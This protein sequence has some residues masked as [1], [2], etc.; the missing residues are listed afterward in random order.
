[1]TEERE[2]RLRRKID[3]LSDQVDQLAEGI[4]RR[5]RR[6]QRLEM[7]G[8]SLRSRVSALKRSRQAV[9][10]RADAWRALYNEEHKRRLRRV[11]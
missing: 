10:E 6:I 5:D 9:K 1:M 11:S 4:L 7:E 2:L 3:A 8:W